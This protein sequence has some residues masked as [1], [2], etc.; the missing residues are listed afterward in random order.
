MTDP[1]AYFE[2]QGAQRLLFVQ[3]ANDMAMTAFAR[4]RAK[5]V[6][7]EDVVLVIA[8]ASDVAGLHYIRAITREIQIE[9]ETDKNLASGFTICVLPITLAVARRVF[10]KSCNTLRFLGQMLLPGR[11]RV[12]GITAG[13]SIFMHLPVTPPIAPAGEA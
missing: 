10:L 5:G 12:V 4:T 13:G 2:G 6:A 7:R 11:V 9:E 1:Q 3:N 8:N